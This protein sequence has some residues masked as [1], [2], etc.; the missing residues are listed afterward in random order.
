MTAVAAAARPLG[1]A[2]PAA[3]LALATIRRMPRRTA[4]AVVP[5]R[6]RSA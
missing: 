2:G 5:S 4:S 6:S 1:A 3:R